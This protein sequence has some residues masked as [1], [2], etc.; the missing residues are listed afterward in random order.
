[1]LLK[2]LGA[3]SDDAAMALQVEQ[4]YWGILAVVLA[5]TG[6]FLWAS[7]HISV[8]K[9]LSGYEGTS[10]PDASEKQ[11]KKVSA[12]KAQ[13][14]KTSVQDDQRRAL[15]L[16]SLLQREGRLV[17]FLEEDLKPYDDAQIGAAV[18]SIQESCQKSLNEYL[19]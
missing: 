5:I 13:E 12:P 16:L 6:F 14:K 18:R 4:L 11:Q 2:W 19:S 17:D 10:A 9:L 8:K 1:M 15:H 3:A 7:L